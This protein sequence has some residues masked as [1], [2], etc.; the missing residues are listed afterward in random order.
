MSTK[1]YNGIK[2]KSNKLGTVIRQLH[3]LKEEA[4]K[5][6]M[7]TFTDPKQLNFMMMCWVYGNAIREDKSNDT[8]WQFQR[9]LRQELRKPYNDFNFMFKV[10]IFERKNK[11]YG[12]YYDHSYLNYKMLF[13][14]DIAVDYHYQDQSDKPDDVSNRDWNF[15]EEV[16]SDIFDDISTLW[17]PSEA[18]AVYDIVDVEDIYVTSSMLDDIRRVRKEEVERKEEEQS[19]NQQ[20]Q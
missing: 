16:W 8:A 14:R 9:I 20:Q 4:V 6:V 15:R 2:F 10:V 1:L 19:E 5:N 7:G 12:I 17:I 11:L 3:G 13:D 18:G